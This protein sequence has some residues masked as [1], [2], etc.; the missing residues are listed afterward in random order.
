MDDGDC[1]QVGIATRFS[2]YLTVIGQTIGSKCNQV[3]L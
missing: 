1:N 3:E 2:A